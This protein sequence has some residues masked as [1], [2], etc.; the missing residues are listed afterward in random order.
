VTNEQE[1]EFYPNIFH[2]QLTPTPF[3]K[4]VR[5]ISQPEFLTRV[6]FQLRGFF[7]EK[8]ALCEILVLYKFILIRVKNVRFQSVK[9][10]ENP[11]I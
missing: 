9:K 4:N 8:G 10:L 7:V 2:F 5:R 11:Y 3:K 1:I 6:G